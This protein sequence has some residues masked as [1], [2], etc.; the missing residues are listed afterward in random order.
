MNSIAN[1]RDSD[2]FKNF[3]TESLTSDGTMKNRV[4]MKNAMY[5]ANK[6]H[7][8]NQLHLRIVLSKFIKKE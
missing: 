3:N 4:D 5:G 1:R 8:S 2:Y 7:F 6:S